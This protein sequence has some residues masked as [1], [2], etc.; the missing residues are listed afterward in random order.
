MTA[1][2]VWFGE[3][4]QSKCARLMLLPLSWIYIVG[5][6]AYLGIYRFGIKKAVAPHPNILCIG[7]L[8]AGG[9]GKSPVTALIAQEMRNRGLPVVFGCSAYGSPAAESAQL[10][11][12]GNLNAAEWGDEPA[13][14]RFRFPDVPI[15]VGRARVRAA[16]ICHQTFPQSILI[17]DDG[18]Q[19]LPLKKSVTLIIDDPNPIN[20]YCL[21]AGPYR[22]PRF[23]RKRADIV[24]P[25]ASYELQ[26]K[27]I[28]LIKP[29][30]ESTWEG[31]RARLLTAIARPDRLIETLQ[32]HCE[33][34]LEIIE[35]VIR[36]DHDPLTQIDL[37]QTGDSV[38]WLV[39]R[40]DWVKL[41]SRADWD[42][43]QSR[44][45]VIE[46]T[47]NL[48]GIEN[49]VDDILKRMSMK[50]IETTQQAEKNR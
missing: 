38:P 28:R 35:K 36:P 24:I 32:P 16:E 14:L 23:N 17:M 18:F 47:L 12:D 15:I 7:N 31:K 42:D 11:P 48:T 1:H 40:K 41:R 8:T 39:T 46:R 9:S 25:S 27:E 44:V 21:P 13:E 26:T 29:G 19:H 34:G 4:W 49:L 5:W 10:A 6:Q 30:P 45:I 2:Q 22:E 43:I 37:L 3:S 20:S 33:A 50:N